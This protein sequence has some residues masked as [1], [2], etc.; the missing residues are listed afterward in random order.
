M[1]TKYQN[2]ITFLSTHKIAYQIVKEKSK[3]LSIGCGRGFIEQSLEKNKKCNVKGIDV[4]NK[5]L[6]KINN[7]EK[8]NL[9]LIRFN[10]LNYDY[11]LLLDIL[12]HLDDPYNLL[13]KIK[14]SINDKNKK[15]TLIISVPNI[16][17]IWI[18]LNLLFGNFNYS[19]RGILDKTHKV[20]FTLD[21]LKKMI[22]KQGFIVK[23]IY[24]VPIPFP[25]FIKNYYISLFFI[26][27]Y[28]ILTQLFSKVFSYQYLMIVEKHPRKL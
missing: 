7:Y 3:V 22:L 10:K 23:K 5:K 13:Y 24:Y 9:N 2:K 12:E 25:L 1:P 11:L 19:Q 14:M 15:N 20:F 26:K 17:N 27:T 16:A 21:S 18:R 6:V 8:K 4:L 28:N